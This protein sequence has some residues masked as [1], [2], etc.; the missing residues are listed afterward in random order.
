[1][2]F[3]RT[4][5]VSVLTAVLLAVTIQ[6]VPAS[7]ADKEALRKCDELAASPYDDQRT[8]PAVFGDMHPAAMEWCE[9]ALRAFPDNARIFFQ[10]SL[11]GRDMRDPT[12]VD[13]MLK[14]VGMGYDAGYAVLGAISEKSKRK[15]FGGYSYHDLVLLGLEKELTW[16]LVERGK[17]YEKGYPL[18]EGEKYPQPKPEEAL[19]L[20]ERAA[21]RGYALGAMQAGG[22]FFKG[23]FGRDRRADSIPY[24][25]RAGDMGLP[26]AYQYAAD[27]Y[28]SGNGV[29]KDEIEALRLV[30]KSFDAGGTSAWFVIFNIAMDL[31]VWPK[32]RQDEALKI[33]CGLQD[34]PNADPQEFEKLLRSLG[35]DCNI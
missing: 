30:R 2:R 10:K 19:E 27:F 12:L 29:E 31:R 25:K 23:Y 20:Y 4:S 24:L 28:L 9:R 11:I 8:E 14:V 26:I 22:L 32:D 1:M 13:D 35:R 16:A 18:Q 5:V 34:S 21:D 6:T 15:K 17:W 33:L 3:L 7:S